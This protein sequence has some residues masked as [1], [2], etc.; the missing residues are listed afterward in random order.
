MS[1]RLMFDLE[2]IN[3]TPMTAGS[4]TDDRIDLDEE[5]EAD[6]YESEKAQKYIGK[7]LV[8]EFYGEA[9][10]GTVQKFLAK[11]DVGAK[12]DFWEIK[13]SD[14]DEE[15]VKEEELL[16]LIE[17]FEKKKIEVVQAEEKDVATD[18]VAR[19]KRGYRIETCIIPGC[20]YVG[21]SDYM[22]AHKASKHGIVVPL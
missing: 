2:D 22:K 12:E 16:S 19:D 21:R 18:F 5:V 20:N 3:S 14:G 7:D 10:T 15:D 6:P 4:E 9:Y 1:A 8:K 13:Y 11:E 17:A